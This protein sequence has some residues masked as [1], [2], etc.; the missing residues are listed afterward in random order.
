[1]TSN[2][3]L[4]RRMS[5]LSA[6]LLTT[7]PSDEGSCVSSYLLRMQAGLASDGS[8]ISHVPDVRRVSV[9]HQAVE[10]APRL[11]VAFAVVGAALRVLHYLQNPGLSLD[12][13]FLALNVLERSPADLLKTLDFNQA[14]PLGYLT[15]VKGSSAL[16]GGGEYALRLPALLASLGSI[17]L[18]AVASRR[19]LPPV[20]AIVATAV[21]ALFDPLIY[22]SAAAK[23]YAFDVLAA[24]GSVS[25]K[26]AALQ[27]FRGRLPFLP[28][29]KIS[30]DRARISE[31][32]QLS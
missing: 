12:E 27:C 8:R 26:P 16:L 1:M 28:M 19:L 13:T 30:T 15:I 21:F 32:P 20:G 23:P 18:F 5:G 11:L 17:V 6:P 22:Y 3:W 29:R 24:T 14:A 31:S 10:A 4:R 2:A 9:S 7:S 25:P